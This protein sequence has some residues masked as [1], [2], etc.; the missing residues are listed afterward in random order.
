MIA[1]CGNVII[2]SAT[3][4]SPNCTKSPAVSWLSCEFNDAA[5]E[6]DFQ[7]GQLGKT[8]AQLSV[9]L[10]AGAL[11]YLLFGLADL[12]RLG[13]VTASYLSIG[14][15]VLV[16]LGA[17][18]GLW[19]LQRQPDSIA[20]ARRVA[21]GFAVAALAAFLLVCATRP[22]E[23][24]WHAM[25]LVIVLLVVYIYLP[26]RV[27]YALALALAGSTGFLFLAYRLGNLQHTE[28]MT[29]ATLLL[30]TN[31]FGVSAARR[32]ERL[33]REDFCAQIALRNLAVRDPLTGC[34]NRRHL[35]EQLLQNELARARRYQ[36]NLSVV[37]CDIDHFR[38]INN[39]YGQAGGD[40]VLR[41]FG[42]LL[43]HSLRPKVDSVV[44]YDAEEFLIILPETGLQEG[45]AVA[46]RL[47]TAFAAS[48]AVDERGKSINATA[49]FGVVSADFT[50]CKEALTQYTIIAQADELLYSAKHGGRNLVR[51]LQLT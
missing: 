9:T 49:S 24:A 44:R 12:S 10:L 30:L 18:A 6:H 14:G 17:L 20:T 13:L 3:T 19:R 41:A 39:Y 29:A 42:T 26:N 37:M 45:V 21:C 31:L 28:L 11:V 23:M 27:A 2:N 38:T 36:L 33:W 40:R 7:S 35:H 8:H 1:N 15:R 47:R 32:Y 43:Q 25:A 50:C 4:S 51:S 16:A 22:A 48:A 46:Q 34:F 5:I